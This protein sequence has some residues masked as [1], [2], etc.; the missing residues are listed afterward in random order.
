MIFGAVWESQKGIP[1]NITTEIYAL[2]FTLGVVEKG[3]PES[4][5]SC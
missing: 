4:A 2:Y 5:I 1:A 3:R